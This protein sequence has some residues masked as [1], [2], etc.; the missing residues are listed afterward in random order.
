[1]SDAREEILD[2]VRS[3]LA[4]TTASPEP[5]ASPPGVAAGPD[6]LDV[7]CERVA[8]YRAVVERCSPDE[9]AARVTAALPEGD[10]VV[11][12]GLSV[13]VPGARVDDGL[14]ATDLDAVAAVVTD[15]RVAVAET[16]T[17][18]LDHGLGQGR[19][20]I[21]LVPDVHVCVVRAD[22]VV[23]DVPDALALLDA[24]RPQT[25]VSGPSATSDIELDRVEGVHGPRTL[26]V[27]VVE[28]AGG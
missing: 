2:R 20:A 21:S 25:W 6:T 7:F 22:Q 4:G 14:S 18:V 5:V 11:P 23:P 8:D 27:V 28:T 24:G 9:V 19:R 12:E 16:G 26:H 1:M 3:A 15:C 13:E 17:I 10:V